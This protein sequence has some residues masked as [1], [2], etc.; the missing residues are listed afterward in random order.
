[1]YLYEVQSIKVLKGQGL[2][3]IKLVK[4]LSNNSEL[5]NFFPLA[6]KM[7]IVNRK[8]VGTIKVSVTLCV[9]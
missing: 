4:T 7:N 6:I 9:C 8:N 3:S 2:L 1:M 5:K